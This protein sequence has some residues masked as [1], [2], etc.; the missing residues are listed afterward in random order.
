M[1]PWSSFCTGKR[2][3]NMRANMESSY[4]V[5]VLTVVVKMLPPMSSFTLDCCIEWNK[6]F[7]ICIVSFSCS[8]ASLSSRAS[9]II[10][11]ASSRAAYAYIHTYTHACMHV[12]ML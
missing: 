1:Q 8:T 12:F 4:L 11:S 10:F 9:R 2:P 3:E 6:S 7:S 5:S